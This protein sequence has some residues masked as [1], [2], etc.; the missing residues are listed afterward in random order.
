MVLSSQNNARSNLGLQPKFPHSSHNSFFSTICI[1]FKWYAKISKWW[2]RALQMYWFIKAL[3]VRF[4][5]FVISFKAS[6]IL[7]GCLLFHHFGLDWH[8][9]TCVSEHLPHLLPTTYRP[10]V[11]PMATALRVVKI[12]EYLET[13]FSVRFYSFADS[14]AK[15]SSRSKSEGFTSLFAC[16]SWEIWGKWF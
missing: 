14:V 16:L 9:W 12:Q 4:L 3:S 11:P 1:I 2:N 8:W 13:F 10:S 6:T 15:L 7:P 5:V